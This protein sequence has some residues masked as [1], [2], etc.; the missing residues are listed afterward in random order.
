MAN[1]VLNTAAL[2]MSIDE[3]PNYLM[4]SFSQGFWPVYELVCIASGCMTYMYNSFFDVV[5]FIA[6][7]L[8]SHKIT[9]RILNLKSIKPI[10]VA[11][12]EGTATQ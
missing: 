3:H 12:A 5:Q 7:F 9:R 11:D 2:K 1:M 4:R 8:F 6:V 10:L